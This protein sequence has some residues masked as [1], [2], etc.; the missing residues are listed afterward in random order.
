MVPR[1]PNPRQAEASD[2][3]EVLFSAYTQSSD[4]L[5]TLWILKHE[6]QSV[7]L[8]A[9]ARWAKVSSSFL[10]VQSNLNISNFN[11][12]KNCFHGS[13]WKSA[14]LSRRSLKSKKHFVAVFGHSCGLLFL[15]P[16]IEDSKIHKSDPKPPWNRLQKSSTPIH[17]NCFH[18]LSGFKV[19]ISHSYHVLK[20]FSTAN[21][22]SS[23]GELKASRIFFNNGYSYNLFTDLLQKRDLDGTDRHAWIMEEELYNL[24]LIFQFTIHSFYNFYNLKFIFSIWDTICAFKSL[25]SPTLH[26]VKLIYERETLIPC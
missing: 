12:L 7:H 5:H 26:T 1:W 25:S 8:Q 11:L 19:F 15:S 16:D 2:H 13:A 9:S 18:F 6:L 17:K 22:C 14:V 23:K 20:L 4:R 24:Q 21:R 3:A 10:K